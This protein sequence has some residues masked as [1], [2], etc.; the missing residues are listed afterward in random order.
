MIWTLN[1][2]L[3]QGLYAKGPWEA[4]VE[5][6]AD[7]TLDELHHIIQQ[8]VEFDDDH[9]YEFFVAR[10]PRSRDRIRFD[11]ENGE[12]YARTIAS[13]F[14]L[15]PDRRLYYLFDYGD[16]WIFQ[17]SRARAKPFVPEAEAEYPRLISE[18]GD[19]PPQYPD[20]DE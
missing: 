20:W 6:D 13:L 19:K 9:L 8:A 1:I 3:I 7:C 12:L 15:P 10:T 5:L 18:R 14:P 2:K 11:E 17:V 16:N 4:A